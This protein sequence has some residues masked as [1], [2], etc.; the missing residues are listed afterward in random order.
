MFL[1]LKLRQKLALPQNRAFKMLLVLSLDG[2][3][4]NLRW[5]QNLH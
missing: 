3:Y 5:L 2:I 1:N 4:L